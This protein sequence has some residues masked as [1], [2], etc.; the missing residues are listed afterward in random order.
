MDKEQEQYSTGMLILR[1]LKSMKHL[2]SWIGLA[3]CFA[4]LGQ[5]VTV[6]IPVI[7]VSL[8]FAG[9]AGQ[10]ISMMWLVLLLV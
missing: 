2:L 8:A 10:K 4:V 1:L 9:L 3:V 7:L 5:V 6:A